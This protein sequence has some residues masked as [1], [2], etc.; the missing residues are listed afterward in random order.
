MHI[1]VQ[2]RK[3]MRKSKFWKFWLFS[4]YENTSSGMTVSKRVHEAVLNVHFLQ[5]WPPYM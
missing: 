2:S 3:M 5:I 1:K 4:L